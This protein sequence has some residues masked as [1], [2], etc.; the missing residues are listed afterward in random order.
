MPNTITDIRNAVKTLEADRDRIDLQLEH[1]RGALAYF[2]SHATSKDSGSEPPPAK[3]MRNEMVRILSDEGTPLHYKEIYRRL[4]A[5]GTHVRGDRPENN[6]G[7]HLSTDE[8]FQ[9]LGKGMWGLKSWEHAKPAET[10]ETEA[11]P[12]LREVLGNTGKPEPKPAES[13]LDSVPF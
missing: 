2:E 6:V 5:R 7:A 12:W 3:A 8:R 1:L 9:T 13:E 10:R 11:P 4:L